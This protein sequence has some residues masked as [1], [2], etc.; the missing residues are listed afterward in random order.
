MCIM[1]GVEVGMKNIEFKNNLSVCS[2]FDLIPY[3]KHK[4]F[5]F[6][7][8]SLENYNFLKVIFNVS[9]F[10][11]V[12][13]EKWFIQASS[14]CVSIAGNRANKKVANHT[15]VSLLFFY[16]TSGRSYNACAVMPPQVRRT[17]VA[18]IEAELC[19]WNVRYTT[20][21]DF[22]WR[23][24]IVLLD[25]VSSS[26]WLSVAN[27]DTHICSA[28]QWLPEGKLQT[29]EPFNFFIFFLSQINCSCV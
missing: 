25:N 17:T 15:Q 3:W 6:F 1:G 4:E 12:Y 10:R 2:V 11:L 29:N 13:F 26:A 9:F 22:W 24:N 8:N 18:L 23:F 21:Y 19:L 16:I 5:Q 14:F 27:T 28:F 20:I 7:C